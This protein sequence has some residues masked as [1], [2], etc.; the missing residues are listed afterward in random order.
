V[1]DYA[2]NPD[3]T[4]NPEHLPGSGKTDMTALWDVM[5]YA[6]RPSATEQKYYVTGINCVPEIARQ[7]MTLTKMRYGKE[8]GIVAFHA[9]QSFAPGEVTPQKAHAIGKELARCLWGSRFEVVVA[10]HLDKKHIHCHFVINSVSFKD[11]KRYNDCKASYR[12]FREMSDQICREQRL[13]VIKNPSPT[14]T[15]RAIYMAEKEGKPTL[16]NVIRADIDAAIADS[17]LPKQ[18]YEE[19]HKRGY[20]FKFRKYT[21]VRPLGR[22]RFTRLK[23]LGEDYDMDRICERIR[24]HGFN[25]DRYYRPRQ[26]IRN[27]TY[28]LIGTLKPQRKITGLQALYLHY[29]YKMGIL[30]KNAPRKSV[31]PLLKSDLLQMDAIA[32]ETRLLCKNHISTA[33][34]LAA[35]KAELKADMMHL[36]GK[37]TKLNNRLRRVADPEEIQQIKEQRTTLTKK[38]LGIRTNLRCVAGIEIRSGIISEKLRAMA[39]EHRQE[40]ARVKQ[41]QA[42]KKRSY[43]R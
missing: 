41:K 7:Q 10:T 22:E 29:C 5:A 19:M 36:D 9:Y 24:E 27:K 39:E 11:G 23:T 33:E 17:N 42:A 38:I 35:F 20:E 3:K 13:S 32:A 21:A 14:H 34:E 40:E 6:T 37:R 12:E 28:Q 2:T 26:P 15:P 16:Y 31:H 4:G 43:E 30:P 18:F 8:G 1:V 25:S